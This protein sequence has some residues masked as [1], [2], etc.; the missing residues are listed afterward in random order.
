MLTPLLIMVREGFEAALIVAILA[1][2]LRRIDRL[3][4][5]RQMWQGVGAAIAIA[6]VAGVILDQAIGG[7]TGRSRLRAFAAISIFAAVV[8]TWMIFWMRR[9]ARSISGD[10][11]AKVDHAIATGEGRVKLAV[12]GVAFVAVLREGLEAALFLVATSTTASGAKVVTGAL[13]GI[14]IAVALG[15]MV[16]VF[17]RQLPMK[18]FFLVT[19][20]VIVVF[21]AGLLARTVAYLQTSG[22]IGTAWNNVYDLT[23]YRWLT[24][25]SQVGQF[26]GALFGWDPRPSIEQILAWLLY[27]VPVSALFLAGGKSKPA[28]KS[29]PAPEKVPAQQPAGSA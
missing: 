7:L 29:G 6:A 15:V 10:L 17:G 13:I 8:L 22:D 16:N 1:V 11:R 25:R 28:A 4:L 14:A 27:L 3:D 24:T 9:H 5:R 18:Q 21:A 2:Y 19:G 26:L 20:M 23:Q 12:F